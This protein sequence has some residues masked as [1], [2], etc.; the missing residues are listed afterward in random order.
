MH[1]KKTHYRFQLVNSLQAKYQCLF[2]WGIFTG[3]ILIDLSL[4]DCNKGHI[5]H[6]LTSDLRKSECAL[7]VMAL[8]LKLPLS[9]SS[10]LPVGRNTYHTARLHYERV[11]ERTENNIPGQWR[12]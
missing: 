9:S 3:Y 2:V 8:S 12:M 6:R 5:V 10:L 4:S 1:I 11:K 7:C